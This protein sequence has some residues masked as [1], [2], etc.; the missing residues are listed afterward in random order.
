MDQKYLAGFDRQVITPDE[1]IPLGGFS[2][3][4]ARYM[5]AITEDICVTCLAITDAE[6]TTVMLVD[7]DLMRVNDHIGEP[8]RRLISRVT[9]IPEDKIIMCATH[10][11][12]APG[13]DK[14]DWP[15][16]QR[17]TKKSL[18]KWSRRQ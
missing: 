18:K 5:K 14:P 16:I 2:N 12:S 11:H 15:E 17:Y 6:D 1:P 10:T 4:V 9:G 8:G 3:E 7:M 13:L